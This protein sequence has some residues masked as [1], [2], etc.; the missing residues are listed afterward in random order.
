[1]NKIDNTILLIPTH[2]SRLA[3]YTIPFFGID[4]IVC[5]YYSYYRLSICLFMLA[6]TSIAHWNRQKKKGIERD[7][8]HICAFVTFTNIMIDSVYMCPQ[9]RN[10]LYVT[11]TISVT[12][13]VIN[14]SIFFYIDNTSQN[15][16]LKE[17][18]N[19]ITTFI[20]MLFLHILPNISIM[21]VLFMCNNYE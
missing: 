14:Q 5:F 17:M 15:M 20:H 12:T 7:I 4:S 19:Y 21:Y 13:F 3:F 8:D 1:M 6:L 11:G 18:N 10:V 16:R 9:Y 2:I